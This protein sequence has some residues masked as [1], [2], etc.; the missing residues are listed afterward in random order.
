MPLGAHVLTRVSTH[1]YGVKLEAS[2]KT[3][4][5]KALKRTTRRVSYAPRLN[6]VLRS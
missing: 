1:A 6:A 4:E 5:L 3:E 2:A